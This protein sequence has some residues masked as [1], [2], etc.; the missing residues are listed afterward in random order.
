MALRRRRRR[1]EDDV[2]RRADRPHGLV[3]L[4]ELSAGRHVVEGRGIEAIQFALSDLV[5]R[6]PDTGASPR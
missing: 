1:R 6:L 3:Q 4:G 2:R 5:K